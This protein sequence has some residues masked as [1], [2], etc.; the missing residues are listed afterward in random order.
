MTGAVV[1]WIIQLSCLGDSVSSGGSCPGIPA[2]ANPAMTIYTSREACEARLQRQPLAGWGY[3]GEC[4]SGNA[5]TYLPHVGFF[6][7]TEP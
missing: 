4:F 1:F 2:D 6:A 3:E 5:I 7:I